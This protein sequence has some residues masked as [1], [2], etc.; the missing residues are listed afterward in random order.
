MNEASWI[1]LLKVYNT[2]LQWD[3]IQ[4]MISDNDT[5]EKNAAKL[6]YCLIWKFI[7]FNNSEQG[8]HLCILTDLIKQVF[9]LTHNKLSHSE[10]IC[11]HEYLTQDL[12]IHNLL[13][14]LHDFI[15]YS[16]QCQ[17]NQTP[18]HTL[19]KLMQSILSLLQPFYTI[20]LNFIL[21]LSI[22][23]KVYNT[24][25]SVTDKFS[26]AFTFVSDKIIWEGKKWA[27]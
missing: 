6:L 14:Q 27:V 25:M 2:E 10:Y 5:L 15:R 23:V 9:Q 7:Y 22:S 21:G 4:I 18:Q 13:K 19:Y 20:T 11:T 24:V 8:L 1:R 3:C 12:Y 17:L 16:S 26:K